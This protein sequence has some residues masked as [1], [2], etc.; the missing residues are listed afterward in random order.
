MIAPEEEKVEN[1]KP[2][3]STRLRLYITKLCKKKENLQG[4]V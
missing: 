3:C 2:P 1:T 4:P